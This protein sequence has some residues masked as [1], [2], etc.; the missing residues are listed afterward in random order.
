M[1]SSHTGPGLAGAKLFLERVIG[2]HDA[3]D[4]PPASG[5]DTRLKDLEVTS[6][7][8]GKLC[9]RILVTEG[10]QNR[11]GTL[12]G[13]CIGEPWLLNSKQTTK[14]SMPS[15]AST[16]T[17]VDTVSTGAL[18]TVSEYSGVSVNLAV[19]YLRPACVAR[20]LLS[21][22]VSSHQYIIINDCEHAGLAE[23]S[24]TWRRQ[25]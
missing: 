12:H 24:L 23:S 20:V 9:A 13:G 4:S 7:E 14:V 5:W 18:L 19:N 1:H 21:C 16:A 11:Y 6:V 3:K 22:S 25:S 15:L 8:K 10:L 17:L 2:K